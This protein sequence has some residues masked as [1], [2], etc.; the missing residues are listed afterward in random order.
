[1]EKYFLV[2]RRGNIRKCFGCKD[3][4]L[5]EDFVVRHKRLYRY[6]NP[7]LDEEREKVGNVY[8]HCRF[9]CIRMRD[10]NFDGNVHS[11]YTSISQA[12]LG[13]NGLTFQE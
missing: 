2:E 7:Q 4:L 13:E 9:R 8:F 3:S 11:L 6:F 5:Y 1:M 10:P 12:I